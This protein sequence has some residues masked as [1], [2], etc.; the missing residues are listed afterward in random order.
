LDNKQFYSVLPLPAKY[1]ERGAKT[2]G[3]NQLIVSGGPLHF[4]RVYRQL[5]QQATAENLTTLSI[6]TACFSKCI[7]FTSRAPLFIIS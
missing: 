4:P 2:A 5:A 6:L 7:G 3:R 1:R